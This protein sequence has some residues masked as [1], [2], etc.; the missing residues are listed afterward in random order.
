MVIVDWI[1]SLWVADLLYGKDNIIS[2]MQ[3]VHNKLEKAFD[4]GLPALHWESSKWVKSMLRMHNFKGTGGFSR[5][6]GWNAP[7]P[8]TYWLSSTPQHMM[9]SKSSFTNQYSMNYLSKKQ[10][11]HLAIHIQELFS[12][13]YHCWYQ[14]VWTTVPWQTAEK[15]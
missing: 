15:W 1:E 7:N 6:L 4:L 11:W 9:F 10:L 12:V 13:L 8:H 14:S 3:H 2:L 5:H